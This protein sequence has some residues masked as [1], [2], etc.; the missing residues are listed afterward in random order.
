[1]ILRQSSWGSPYT[2][3][4]QELFGVRGAHVVDSN[5]AVGTA[6]QTTVGRPDVTIAVLDSGIKWYDQ[7]SMADLRSKILDALFGAEEEFDYTS[8]TAPSATPT[9]GTAA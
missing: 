8:T 9:A 1:M 4:A 3:S 5:P 6:W 7:G 2:T